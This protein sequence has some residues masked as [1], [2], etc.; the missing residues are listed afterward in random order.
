METEERF[1]VKPPLVVVASAGDAGDVH[2]KLASIG[3]TGWE[4]P[5]R[6]T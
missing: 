5:G 2:V 6:F 3:G 4:T 1:H